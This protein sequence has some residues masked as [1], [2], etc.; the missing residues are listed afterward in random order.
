[1]INY[2]YYSYQQYYEYDYDLIMMLLIMIIKS[3][4]DITLWC[5]YDYQH[6]LGIANDNH[7]DV[8][9]SLWQ[10]MQFSIGFSK[11]SISD[12]HNDNL[13]LVI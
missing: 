3:I 8:G 13:L 7:Y 6:R 10:N 9:L 2:Y 12:D 1:M 4:I 5:H 11:I